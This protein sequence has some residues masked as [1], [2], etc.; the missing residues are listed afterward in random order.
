MKMQNNLFKIIISMLIALTFAGGSTQ[1]DEIKRHYGQVITVYK[2]PTCGCC[3]GWVDY[4]RTNG[5]RVETHDLDDLSAVKA[6]H[7]LTDPALMSCHTAIVD[8]YI[9]E[10][11]V[12]ADDIWRL[13]SERPAVTGIS[14]P[15]MPQL[16]PGMNS[17]EPQG[18]DVLS[19]DRQGQVE[20]FSRY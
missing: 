19:F 6:Q 12:P 3:Q 16:S 18:Y 2:T 13:L 9:V 11:H 7:G 20:L 4:L 1:A 17:I 10:G 5:F 14:A 15:G 8:G